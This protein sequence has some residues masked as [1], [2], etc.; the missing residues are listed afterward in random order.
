MLD[1]TFIKHLNNI[2]MKTALIIVSILI[3]M[4]VLY[5]VIFPALIFLVK[6]IIAA[7]FAGT[8]GAGVYVGYVMNGKNKE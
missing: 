7:A 4:A 5:Y 1:E 2:K 3:C 8:F 6:V